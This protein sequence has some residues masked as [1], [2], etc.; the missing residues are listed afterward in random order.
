MSKK[1]FFLIALLHALSVNAQENKPPSSKHLIKTV[2]SIEVDS[3]Y[4]NGSWEPLLKQVK[5]KR[6]VLLGE[7]NH[8]SKEIFHSRNDLI[9]SL[10][11]E[12]GFDVVLFESGI[13]ELIEIDLKKKTLKP[14]EMIYGF[15][16]GWRTREFIQ[17]M[18]YVKTNNISISGFDVQRTGGSFQRVL[19]EEL[20]R[21]HLNKDK[22]RDIEKRFSEEKSKLTDRDAVY[23]S[24]KNSVN[25]LI[26]D[27]ESLKSLMKKP[28][29]IELSQTSQFVIRTIENRVK[30]L[31]YYLNFVR[32]K[33]WKKR[34]KERDFMMF[35]NIAWLLNKIY[36][37]QKVIVIAHNFH[38]SKFNKNEEVMGAFLKKEYDSDM[39]SIGVFA[40][41]GSFLNN[42]GLEEK[43]TPISNDGLDIKQIINRCNFKVAFLNIPLKEKKGMEWLYNKIIVNDTF[44]DLS[45]SNEMV[46]SK[47]FDGLIFIDQISPA[48]KQ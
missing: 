7:L 42:K 9:K 13:G 38:I 4:Q 26:N 29:D 28:E 34:W 15:F 11:E 22:Y 3:N 40:G 23:D 18:D 1:Y 36:K 41:K 16:G 24:L 21:L 17:L 10:H 39:Y 31:Q 14:N 2:T 32:D 47:N 12:L 20:F 45:S 35:S 30:Y 6:I 37:N 19:N 43:L 44:I 8:G 27:Y 33:D 25:Y 46:L 48:I 5:N